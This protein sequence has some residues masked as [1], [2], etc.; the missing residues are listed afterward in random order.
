VPAEANS[1]ANPNSLRLSVPEAF[2]AL[3]AGAHVPHGVELQLP[4]ELAELPMIVKG[5]FIALLLFE[6]SHIS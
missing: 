6:R 5:F 2:L 1:V 3:G 4:H